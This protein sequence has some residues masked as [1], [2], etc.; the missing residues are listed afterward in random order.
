MATL[1]GVA[2]FLVT[3]FTV[4]IDVNVCKMKVIL[5]AGRLEALPS[6][7]CILDGRK[8]VMVRDVFEGKD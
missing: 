7:G 8:T 1:V 3:N 2:G 6:D 5:I 4:N